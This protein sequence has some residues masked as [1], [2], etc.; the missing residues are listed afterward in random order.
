MFKSSFSL[1]FLTAALFCSG[2]S[3]QSHVVTISSA[4]AGGSK[5]LEV[6][7]ITHIKNG[8]A[9]QIEDCDNSAAQR[10][11]IYYS[12]S[13]YAQIRL[14]DPGL[15]YCLDGINIELRPILDVPVRTRNQVKVW[16]CNQSPP[17]QWNFTYGGFIS[18]VHNR[19]LCLDVPNSNNG[20]QAQTNP[21]NGG[22]N[23]KWHFEFPN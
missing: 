3:A 8:T 19:G 16:E 15:N 1:V 5:C 12:G 22:L 21:C 13:A 11:S 6:S 18:L 7:D 23:Q 20:V 14:G 10:W 9:V 2:V 17:Q 4:L